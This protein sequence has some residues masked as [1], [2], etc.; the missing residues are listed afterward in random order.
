MTTRTLRKRKVDDTASLPQK[1]QRQ[2]KKPAKPADEG[3][4]VLPHNMGPVPSIKQHIKP[5]IQPNSDGLEEAGEPT[6][7][8]D[9]IEHQPAINETVQSHKVSGT[10]RRA[11]RPRRSTAQVSYLESDAGSNDEKKPAKASTRKSTVVKKPMKTE[12]DD[13]V[14]MDV[15]RKTSKKTKANPYGLTPGITPFPDWA[16]PSAAD[17]E[18][19]Y[20]RLA[21]VHG[22]SK[23]PDKIPAPSLEVSGCGEVPSVV[24]A[25]IRTRLSANTSSSNSSAAFRGLVNKFGIVNEGIGQGSVDWEK[26]RIAPLESIVAAIKCGGLAQ[27][28][29]KDIKTILQMVHDE[30][31]KRRD[32]FVAEKNTGEAPSV[33]GAEGKT[34]GQK[35]LEILKT[36]Q[37]ILSLDHI[38]G[39]QPD[40]AMQT[41]VKFPGIGVKTASCVILFCLQQPSFAVDTHVHRLSTW[42]KWIPPKASRD[43]AFSHLEVRIPNHLKYGLHKLFVQHGKSCVR[44]RANTSEGS[45]EYNKAVCPLEGVIDRVGKR[46]SSG[47]PTAGKR[48][49]KDEDED[50]A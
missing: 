14:T 40:E 15:P 13:D 23:A 2:Q 10:T 32:A 37:N 45:E 21:K 24:D 48:K 12:I 6:K 36:D 16:A 1:R 28:K 30:N 26:V 3:L 9:D 43:E 31:K 7:E 38:H 22:E 46:K 5:E 47:K 4:D 19:V 17:C 18:D 49:V 34:Q 35:D 8:E 44:C 27:I 41:L 50:S 29:G 33:I 20:R 11:L 39:M 42:L 25:L